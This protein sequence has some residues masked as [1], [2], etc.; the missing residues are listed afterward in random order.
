MSFESELTRDEF[1][2]ICSDIW[3]RMLE[4]IQTSLE[5]AEL[6]IDALEKVVVVGGSTRIPK[7]RSTLQDYFGKSKVHIAEQ[8]EKSIA[9]GAAWLAFSRA[10]PEKVLQLTFMGLGDPE[11]RQLQTRDYPALMAFTDGIKFNATII[12]VPRSSPFEAQGLFDQQIALG[13]K[14][15]VQVLD[16]LYNHMT[17]YTISSDDQ[18]ALQP[19]ES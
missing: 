11:A 5:Q 17:R 6:T 10:N 13:K 12:K 1:E 8:P 3:I 4:P 19:L 9:E 14:D 15:V 16:S 18:V 7:I 2:D